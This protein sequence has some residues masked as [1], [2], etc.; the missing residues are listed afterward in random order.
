MA[1][2]TDCFAGFVGDTFYFSP[3][4]NG[5]YISGS[6]YFVVSPTLCVVVFQ[7]AFR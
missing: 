5:Q 6:K 2:S 1:H 4:S 3:L 7:V